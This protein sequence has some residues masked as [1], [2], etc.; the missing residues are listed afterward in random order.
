M[1]S[2]CPDSLIGKGNQV[3]AK[4][5]KKQKD[6]LYNM[7]KAIDKQISSASCTS[8]DLTGGVLEKDWK[9]YCEFIDSLVNA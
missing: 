7:T 4:L 3:M 9:T 5:S 6:R 2:G 8:G 1:E